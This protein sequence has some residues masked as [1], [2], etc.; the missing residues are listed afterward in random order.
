MKNLSTKDLCSIGIFTAIIIALS[1]IKIPLPY[2]VPMTLQTFIIPFAAIV[3]GAKRGT[4]SALLYVVLGAL[5]LP[6]FAGFT[7]GLGFVFGMTGG[8]I[9]S[10][11]IMALTAGIGAEKGGKVWLGLGLVI[12]SVIN[13]LCGMLMYSFV[14]GTD[15][16][17]TFVAC[18]LPFIPTAII[19]VILAGMLGVKCKAVLEKGGVLA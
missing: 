17:T 12:G 1:Q 13:Y 14:V 5:G 4:V 8:F 19:K 3:L 7:G 9:L 11:P 6:V 16:K 18:V 15:L 10:F 2:G